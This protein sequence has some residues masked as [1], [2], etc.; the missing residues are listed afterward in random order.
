MTGDRVGPSFDVSTIQRALDALV[1]RDR[2]AAAA[3][4]AIDL[5]LV[6]E[7]GC[8]AGRVVGLGAVLDR[9]GALAART[10]GTFGTEVESVFGSARS[11]LVVVTRHWANVDGRPLR[12]TQALV[13]V[14][15]GER[16]SEMS[17]LSR[18]GISSGIWD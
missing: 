6:G 8:F 7:G 4:F 11:Q 5:V 9:F 16:I 1:S 10:E 18:P 15:D 3:N 2:V 14:T 12:G 17:A 13:L